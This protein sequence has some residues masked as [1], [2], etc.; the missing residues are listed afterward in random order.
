MNTQIRYL[1]RDASNY[2]I[3]NECVVTGELM[4]EQIAQIMDLP[5]GTVKS[6]LARARLQL[7]K[8]LDAGNFFETDASKRSE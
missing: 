5:V 4:P 1:Y 3:H 2:K 6:R 7:K 8:R